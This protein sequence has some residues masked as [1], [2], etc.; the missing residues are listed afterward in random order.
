[1][2]AQSE[3]EPIKM[4]TSG[5]PRPERAGGVLAFIPGF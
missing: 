1:M 5:L 4:T 3:S 2:T